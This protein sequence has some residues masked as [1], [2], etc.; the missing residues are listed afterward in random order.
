MGYIGPCDLVCRDDR[1]SAKLI[2]LCI[3]HRQVG[4][5]CKGRCLSITPSLE[6]TNL[7]C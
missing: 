3:V 7:K 4:S 5:I 1:N 6:E 2:R